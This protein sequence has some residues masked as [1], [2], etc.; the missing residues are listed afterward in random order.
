[1]M[2]LLITTVCLNIYL[3]AIVP[4]GFF[5][6]QDTGR[7]TGNIQADQS[8][9]F[10]AM[11]QKLAISWR[12]SKRSGGGYRGGLHRRLPRQ[13]GVHVRHA[14]TAQTSELSVDQVIA[15]LRGK[16]AHEPGA[17]L[18]LQAAQDIR[19]GGRQSNAQYQYTLQADHLDDLR[20]WAPRILQA[21]MQLHE[22][23]D[24]NSDQQD[25]GTQISLIIDRDTAYRLGVTPSLIDSTLNDA[26]GQ[27]QVSTIYNPLNQYKV[28]MEV[29]PEYWQS[30]TTL[31]N[32]VC[33][34]GQRSAGSAFGFYAL[35]IY[36]HAARSEPSGTVCG[37]YN[38]VQSAY[39]CFAFGCD[40]C[41]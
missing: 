35:R 8:I 27:R 23:A 15:R 2:F 19:M 18:F 7:L 3:Y 14:Q 40:A 1:M 25:N 16:L 5:P 41:N 6:Q 24:V 12:S 38:L 9:S 34:H 20:A 30:P 28:V 29:A 11:R 21:M 4:K 36:Q 32:V 31:D 22:L 13:L 37:I 10:Q 26:F 17:K 33:Q 39:R